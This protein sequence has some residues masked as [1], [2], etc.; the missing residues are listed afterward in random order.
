MKLKYRIILSILF[1]IA[2]IIYYKI[3]DYKNAQRLDKLNEEY[4]EIKPET[5]VHDT[6]LSL[7]F[8]EKMRGAR[9]YQY[10][11][12]KHSKIRLHVDDFL[13]E[14]VE[15]LREILKS[16]AIVVKKSNTDTVTVYK[17]SKTYYLK[18]FVD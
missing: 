17:N 18:V 8:P 12:L 16:G 13:T 5:F 10:I 4:R 1:I 15:D 14:G 7:Y 2:F 9:N 6:V 3:D 11:T